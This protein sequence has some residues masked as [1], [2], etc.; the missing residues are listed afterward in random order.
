LIEL[1]VCAVIF[2]VNFKSGNVGSSQSFLKKDRAIRAAVFDDL[3][4]VN[5]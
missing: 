2:S 4:S 1:I 5:I 3:L